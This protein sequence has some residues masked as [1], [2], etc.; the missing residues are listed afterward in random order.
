MHVELLTEEDFTGVMYT[1]GSFYKQS[2]PCFVKPKVGRQTRQLEMKFSMNQCQTVKEGDVYS[3]VVVVQHDPELV[4]PGDAA[5]V[6]ECDFRQPRSLNVGADIQTTDR[7][8]ASNSSVHGPVNTHI[9]TN[10]QNSLRVQSRITLTSP[11][12]SV[13]TAQAGQQG[14]KNTV[15]SE[16]G[17]VTYVPTQVVGQKVKGSVETV[18]I[19]MTPQKKKE[20]L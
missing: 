4:T 18:T 8:V 7:Y 14:T 5:F 2:E 15:S 6:V 19:D 9:N 16:T 12:P 1:R 3:N 10:T 11:D 17:E 20:E 13:G